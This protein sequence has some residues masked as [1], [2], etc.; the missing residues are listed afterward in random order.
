MVPLNKWVALGSHE[1]A[2][3]TNNS[4]SVSYTAGRPFALQS[5]LYIK[6]GVVKYF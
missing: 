5:T 2:Q 4:S 6:V 1:G 3:N